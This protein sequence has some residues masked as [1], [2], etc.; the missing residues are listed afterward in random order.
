[1]QI[2]Q[3]CIN[4]TPYGQDAADVWG[5]E[6]KNDLSYCASLIMRVQQ[7]ISA[8]ELACIFTD[9]S[10][11]LVTKIDE[12]LKDNTASVLR[13]SMKNLSFQYNARELIANV[14]GRNLL[15][16]A[17]RDKFKNMPVVC[18]LDEA[19]QFLEKVVG[20]ESSSIRLDAFGLIAKEGRKYG[21]T[22]V[23]ATQRPRD[24]PEDVLSQL[25]TLIVH[26]LTNDKDRN[27]VERACGDIDKSAAAFLPML[28]QGEALIVGT[29]FPIPVPLKIATPSKG[30][31]SM[32]P[33][34]QQHWGKKPVEAFSAEKETQAGE[35]ITLDDKNFTPPKTGT[36]D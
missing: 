17:R 3:E 31:N 33:Q 22:C 1:M 18:L 23:F 19:H 10:D 5:P 13:V 32:G 11:S 21:L 12:F 2:A 6:N 28:D 24:I 30:P 8:P 9:T 15:S 14:I 16:E 20:D 34:Y 26:R 27:V 7:R 25:G 35:K 29:D 36:K 4:P